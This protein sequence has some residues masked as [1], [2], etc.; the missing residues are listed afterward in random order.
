MPRYAAKISYDGTPY[1]GYQVQK[2]G[3]TVQAE[4][5]RALALMAK[6]PKGEHLA[7][8]ASGRTDSGVHARGQVLHFDYPASIQAKNIQR[9]LN[10]IMDPSVRVEAVRE[11]AADFNARYMAR[12]KRYLYRVDTQAYPDPFKRLYTLHHP[13]TCDVN[14]MQEAMQVIVGEHDFT[15]FCST[16]TD[17]TDLVR[18]VYRAEVVEVPELQEI[19]FTFEGNGFLYNMLRILVGTALQIGDGLKDVGEIARL[20]EVK[21]RSEAG[22]TAPPHGLYLMEVFYDED[23]FHP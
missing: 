16:K 12:S 13:Y 19:H 11:V 7:T 8:Y 5:E 4:I 3:H 9:A 21:E 18:T 20:L 15:S 22:P 2:N 6:L 17:K 10:A 1:V 23:P 14:R